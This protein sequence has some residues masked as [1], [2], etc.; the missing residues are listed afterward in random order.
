M[1]YA[2][3]WDQIYAIDT[4]VRYRCPV[5]VPDNQG[6]T[7]LHLAAKAGAYNSIWT[8]SRYTRATNSVDHFGMTPLHLAVQAGEVETVESL[9]E[10]PGIRLDIVP[11]PIELAQTRYRKTKRKKYL[12]IIELLNAGPITKFKIRKTQD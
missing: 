11:N 4:M 6:R 8:L 5:D 12:K 3:K 10:L 1:H 2:A 7:P 9:L